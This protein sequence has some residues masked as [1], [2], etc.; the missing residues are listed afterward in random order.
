MSLSVDVC[1][2]HRFEQSGDGIRRFN[3]NVSMRFTVVELRVSC[4]VPEADWA[5][6]LCARAGG[7]FPEA[8]RCFQAR[9]DIHLVSVSAVSGSCPDG[10][11]TRFEACRVSVVVSLVSLGAYVQG[12]PRV[13]ATW[14][15]HVVHN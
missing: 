14:R 12:E 7:V 2:Q 8:K 15:C 10:G 13:N 1:V 9:N 11:M 6:K 5:W 4:R 3:A